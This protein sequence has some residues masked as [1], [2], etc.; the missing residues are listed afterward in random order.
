M[1][2]ATVSVNAPP[3]PTAERDAAKKK[4]GGL[5]A[6]VNSK[7]QPLG[8]KAVVEDHP[9]SR[10]FKPDPLQRDP[11]KPKTWCPKNDDWAVV[12][13]EGATP[14]DADRFRAAGAAH[15]NPA[16]YHKRPAEVVALAEKMRLTGAAYHDAFIH[17]D[18]PLELWYYEQHIIE[19]N[20]FLTNVLLAE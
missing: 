2:T 9:A 13:F 4:L 17:D 16:K 6:A 8:V 7:L 10:L 15:R 14:A 5:I 18:R 12:F 3:L 20:N 11:E 1:A 19:V